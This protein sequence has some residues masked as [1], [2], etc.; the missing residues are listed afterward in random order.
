LQDKIKLDGT[1]RINT[2]FHRLPNQVL[3]NHTA[4]KM[5]GDEKYDGPVSDEIEGQGGSQVIEGVV[6]LDPDTQLQRGLKSRHIQFLALGG[7]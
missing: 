4:S 3:P 7:A 5:K 2:A 6:S 1:P